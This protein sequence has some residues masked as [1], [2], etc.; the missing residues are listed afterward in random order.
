ML[1][2]FELAFSLALC[3]NGCLSITLSDNLR[4]KYLQKLNTMYTKLGL[5][6]YPALFIMRTVMYLDVVKSLKT[7]LQMDPLSLYSNLFAVYSKNLITQLI[8]TSIVLLLY[9][10]CFIFTCLIV[11]SCNQLVIYF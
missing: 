10:L 4:N 7:Q 2:A 11:K 5:F 8:V 1:Y 6:M 9:L 3:V